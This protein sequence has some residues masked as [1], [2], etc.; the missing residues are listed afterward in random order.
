M[1]AVLLQLRTSVFGDLGLDI[2]DLDID[3]LGLGGRNFFGVGGH[4]DFVGRGNVGHCEV[5]L[6]VKLSNKK[7][8]DEF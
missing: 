2:R 6:E 7:I 1:V 3:N 5:V 8:K 4:L